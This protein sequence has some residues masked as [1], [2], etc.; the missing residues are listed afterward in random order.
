MHQKLQ[1]NTPARQ[2]Q[3]KIWYINN[4]YMLNIFIGTIKV[5][6]VHSS[7]QIELY[8]A[9]RLVYKFHHPLQMINVLFSSY[10]LLFSLLLVC[11]GKTLTRLKGRYDSNNNH[12]RDNTDTGKHY[13]TFSGWVCLSLTRWSAPVVSL[14][15]TVH[16]SE[17]YMVVSLAHGQMRGG[18]VL[19]WD[20]GHIQL[21]E[22][23]IEHGHNNMS[24]ARASS[25]TFAIYCFVQGGYRWGLNHV[26]EQCH[27]LVI[28]Q[29]D[30]LHKHGARGQRIW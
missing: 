3:D 21:E 15:L 16:S 19:L 26:S 9:K 25:W 14:A 8:M 11:T 24:I 5:Q 10:L 20:Q 6:H 2:L 12:S 1:S 28:A 30:Q 27:I 18:V 17:N 7:K 4:S 13:K 23:Y 22:P 29:L